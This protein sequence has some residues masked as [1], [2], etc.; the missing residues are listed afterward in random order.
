[1]LSTVDSKEP[2]S[3]WQDQVVFS[4]YRGVVNHDLDPIVLP[5]LYE[6][7]S[8]SHHENL[9]DVKWPFNTPSLLE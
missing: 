7:Q 2:A 9:S 6:S 3:H 8:Q 4:Q 1:M 5:R